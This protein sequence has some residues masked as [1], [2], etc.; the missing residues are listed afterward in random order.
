[1]AVP[2]V[3]IV[4]L[5]NAAFDASYWEIKSRSNLLLAAY[6]LIVDPLSQFGPVLIAYSAI[7]VRACRRQRLKT[8]TNVLILCPAL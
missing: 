5:L 3:I 8:V 6:R 2:Y 4:V 7:S 1:V